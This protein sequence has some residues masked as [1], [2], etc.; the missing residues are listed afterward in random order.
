VISCTMGLRVVGNLDKFIY[1]GIMVA[2]KL[3][4]VLC[5]GIKDF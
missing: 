1:Y 5:Y 4:D 3:V 2:G